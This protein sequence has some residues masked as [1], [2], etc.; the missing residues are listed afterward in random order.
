MCSLCSSFRRRDHWLPQMGMSLCDNLCDTPACRWHMYV[1]RRH[2]QLRGPFPKTRRNFSPRY[3]AR[4]NGTICVG[5][6]RLFGDPDAIGQSASTNRESI[7]RALKRLKQLKELKRF[8]CSARLIVVLPGLTIAHCCLSRPIC[9][10]I[11]D[12]ATSCFPAM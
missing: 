4:S 5:H 3:S 12:L 10:G 7:P 6:L 1:V 9:L 2:A 11:C 8:R